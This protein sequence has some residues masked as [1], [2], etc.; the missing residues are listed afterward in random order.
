MVQAESRAERAERRAAV[1]EARAHELARRLAH[2]ER[3]RRRPRGQTLMRRAFASKVE[4]L[5]LAHAR[6][7]AQMLNVQK[8][9]FE[10]ELEALAAEASDSCAALERTIVA[11]QRDAAMQA[12]RL[13]E[14]E[15]RAARAE[16]LLAARELDDAA[17]AHA[18]TERAQRRAH[19]CKHLHPLS[20]ARVAL[21][22]D[23]SSGDGD[24]DEANDD[25]HTRT[26]TRQNALR[27]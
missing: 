10:A 7:T 12:A 9:C 27:R 26:R 8:G 14:A 22:S 13:H 19:P 17:N 5:A 11:M 2:S 3:M 24:S 6:T 23:V 16:A 18:L 20:R 25:A 4:E 15:A 21:D 1:G